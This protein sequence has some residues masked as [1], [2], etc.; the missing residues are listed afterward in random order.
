MRTAVL[1][2]LLDSHILEKSI[3]PFFTISPSLG[4]ISRL[5]TFPATHLLS[6][7]ILYSIHRHACRYPLNPSE[8][9]PLCSFFVSFTYFLSIL[10][11]LRYEGNRERERSIDAK[12]QAQSAPIR[13]VSRK[14]GGRN[15]RER[16]R[17]RGR[18]ESG[19][20]RERASC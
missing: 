8:S 10:P 13:A 19:G 2:L 14:K 6:L 1:S 4:I 15:E 3:H 9:R 18:G 11:P 16:K 12:Q 7:Y 17:E 20:E 5:F